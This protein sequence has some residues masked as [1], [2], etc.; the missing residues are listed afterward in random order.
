VLTAGVRNAAKHPLQ[1]SKILTVKHRLIDD[2]ANHQRNT[3]YGERFHFRALQLVRYDSL[4]YRTEIWRPEGQ[5][6]GAAR[7][8]AQCSLR[9]QSGHSAQLL[10]CEP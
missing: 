10:K 3:N 5:G 2:P 7:M 6:T 8:S 1:S 9:G 4:T